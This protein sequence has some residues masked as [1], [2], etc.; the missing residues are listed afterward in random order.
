MEAQ[1][2]ANRASDNGDT[3]PKLMGFSHDGLTSEEARERLGKYGPNELPEH[4]TNAIIKFLS[5]LWG[6]IPWMIEVAAVLSLII[7]HWVDLT[8]IMVL[9]VFNAAVGFWA[10]VPGRQCCCSFEKES[11]A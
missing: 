8:I 3:N 11:G 5:F 4:H 6:P 10:G 2:I 9:L 1:P 7:G